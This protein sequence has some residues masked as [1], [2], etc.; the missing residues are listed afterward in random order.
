[1]TNEPVPAGDSSTGEL[2]SRAAEQLSTL[3]RNEL[4]LARAEMV[5]KGKRAGMGAGLLGTAGALALYG[6]GVL[7][8]TVVLLLDLV[9]PAWLAALVVAVAVFAI[10]AGLALAGRRQL[11]RA[12]PPLPTAAVESVGEDVETVKAAIRDGR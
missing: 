9:W 3:V 12:A 6:L 1:M 7:I 5:E 8:V 10:A 11:G 2:I 4:A